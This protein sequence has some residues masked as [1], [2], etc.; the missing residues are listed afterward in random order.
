MPEPSAYSSEGNA[1][2]SPTDTS[3]QSDSGTIDTEFEMSEADKLGSLDIDQM[4]DILSVAD[5][6]A[7][8]LAFD[9]TEKIK[10][11][12]SN[13]GRKVSDEQKRI[14]SNFDKKKKILMKYVNTSQAARLIDKVCFIIGVSLLIAHTYVMGHYPNY[15][16]YIW[17]AIVVTFYVSCRLFYYR[18]KKWHY[19]LF[20]FCYFA[21]FLIIYHLIFDPKNIKLL[22]C[23]FIWA[24]GPLSAAIGAFRNSMIFHKIDNLTSVV[25]HAIPM[26]SAY[27]MR[28]VTMEEQ[29]DLP[30][31][32]QFFAPLPPASPNVF[33]FADTYIYMPVILYLLWAFAYYLKIFVVSSGRIRERKYETMY[34]YFQKKPIFKKIYATFGPK[35]TPVAFMLFHVAFFAGSMALALLCFFCHYFHSAY[36]VCWLLISIWNGANFYMEY[37][38]RKYE[39]SLQ[40]LEEVSKQLETANE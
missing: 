39:A 5:S 35:F 33:D 2:P 19:Y 21:N 38:S 12:K 34:V 26:V 1:P 24:S 27:N 3:K 23:N 14:K 20:D 37:F 6:L 22:L 28:W 8:K 11:L 25:I 36:I 4:D 13:V 30:I 16:Y 9:T 17:H 10:R 7:I 31:D 29:K 15:G 32:S 40:R 18:Y